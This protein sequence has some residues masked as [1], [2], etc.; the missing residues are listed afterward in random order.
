MAFVRH[1]RLLV[2]LG[3]LVC[4]PAL[5][6]LVATAAQAL[7]STLQGQSAATD[8][9]P[10]SRIGSAASGTRANGGVAAPV[11]GADPQGATAPRA[12]AGAGRQRPVPPGGGAW[13][14]FMA[15]L[16]VLLTAAVAPLWLAYRRRTRSRSSGGMPDFPPS[17]YRCEDW[18]E[19]ECCRSRTTV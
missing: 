10:A 1:V 3:L 4:G 5:L 18:Q 19:A 7:P 17:Y 2:A 9:V 15:V 14:A 8:R 16:F 6:A 11:R 13:L 12:Q